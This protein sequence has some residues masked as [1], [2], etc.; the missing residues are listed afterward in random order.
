MKTA[1]KKWKYINEL[2]SESLPWAGKKIEVREKNGSVKL[3]KLESNNRDVYRDSDESNIDKLLDSLKL[4]EILSMH[5]C[6][7]AFSF[8]S[9]LKSPSHSSVRILFCQSDQLQEKQSTFR[10]LRALRNTR[11]V[12]DSP[13]TTRRLTVVNFPC[14]DWLSC[15]RTQ[16][17][18]FVGRV[19]LQGRRIFFCCFL[20]WRFSLEAN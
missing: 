4:V 13:F 19:C 5:S 18:A 6:S 9:F 12:G 17:K 2:R 1:K 16:F 10:A 7:T 20:E 3:R 11:I 15:L 8:M 14:A